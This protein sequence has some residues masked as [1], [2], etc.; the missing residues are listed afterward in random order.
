MR[1]TTRSFSEMSRSCLGFTNVRVATRPAGNE[2]FSVSEVSSVVETFAPSVSASDEETVSLVASVGRAA[3]VSTTVSSRSSSRLG[4]ARTR[5][6][7][8]S[9][10]YS[11]RTSSSISSSAPVLLAPVSFLSSS[12]ASPSS[13]A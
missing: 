11:A 3:T 9:A 8:S 5:A 12:A 10:A 1:F 6:S 4:S 13:S 7:S 2:A